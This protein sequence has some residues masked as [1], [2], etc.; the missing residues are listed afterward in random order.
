MTRNRIQPESAKGVAEFC[1]LLRS[2]KKNSGRTLRQL[3][4]EA[5][6]C[7]SILPRSTVADMLRRDAL[8]RPELLAVFVR[9]CGDGQ[10]LA[11]WLS[12]RERLAVGPHLDVE[13]TDPAVRSAVASSGV[14]A[15]APPP[16]SA[17][18]LSERPKRWLAAATAVTVVTIAAIVT[19]VLLNR[20]SGP[21]AP[22]ALPSDGWYLL[23]PGHTADRD[24][25]VG[26]G[27]ERNKRTDRP[28]AVQRPCKELVPDTYLE[29]LGPGVYLIKWR[30]PEQGWGC[31]S[32]DEAS[33]DDSM[34]LAP[35]DCTSAAD[36][37]FLFEPVSAPVPNGFVLRPV[38]SG[39]CVGLLGGLAEIDAGAELAQATCSGRADQV[40]L[41]E[42][43]ERASLEPAG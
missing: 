18:P 23:R 14:E 5:A 41:L 4:E 19:T 22:S 42:P 39:K 20:P 25:C 36:Q 27:R 11:E 32:V 29:A 17:P 13:P 1:A 30:H 9:A 40:F 35:R 28:L 7:G 15:S 8:P 38:H 16:S 43:V 10:H 21:S 12:T 24:L 6:E 34:L 37:R 3:E 26:E 31:L 2:L 33:L